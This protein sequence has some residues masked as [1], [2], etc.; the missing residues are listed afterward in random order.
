MRQ[1]SACMLAA[2]LI[3]GSF[4][5]VAPPPTS[6]AAVRP[7]A[8]PATDALG[9]A[10]DHVLRILNDEALKG[11]AHTQDRRQALRRVMEDVIDFPDA[12]RRAL[13]LH[14]QGRTEAERAEFVALFQD[15]VI[16]S[17]IVTIESYGGQTVVYAGETVSDGGAAVFTKVQGRHGAPIPV[18]YRMHQRDGRW[19]IYDVVIEGVSLVANY[20]TQFHTVVRASS[21]AELVRRIRARVAALMAPVDAGITD[22]DGNVPPWL[23]D[24]IL[25]WLP[26]VRATLVPRT[27]R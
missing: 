12:A 19:L 5:V 11:P 2:A 23:V 15:L 24:R 20:R 1:L 10:I 3:G 22:P 9:P 4:T 25:A 27:G 21:Y 14:W 26:E 17:Y 6:A 16:Y 13:A 8:G 18:E 7:A